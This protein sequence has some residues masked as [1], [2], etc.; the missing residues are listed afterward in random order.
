MVPK[1][2]KFMPLSD[3]ENTVVATFRARND[4]MVA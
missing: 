1:V 2:P 4:E 3:C